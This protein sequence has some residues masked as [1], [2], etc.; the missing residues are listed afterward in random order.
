MVLKKKKK[1]ENK[2]PSSGLVI[3]GPDDLNEVPEGIHNFLI[4]MYGPK[5]IGKTTMASRFP[6]SVIGMLERGR[7]GLNIRQLTLKSF[8]DCLDF[9][10]KCIQ[11]PTV[12][13]LVFDT[14]DV[15]Y[16]QCLL[17]ECRSRGINHP[18]EMKDFG[19][20]WAVIKDAFRDFFDPI[21]ESGK[22]CLCLSHEKKDTVEP[23]SGEPYDRLKPSCSN[24]AY[25]IVEE[26]FDFILYYGKHGKER[27]ISVRP[28]DEATMEVDCCVGPEGVF[29]DPNGEPLS[30]FTVPNDPDAAFATLISAYENEVWDAIRGKPKKKKASSEDDE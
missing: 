19:A 1:P 14:I 7:R 3:P 2:K 16:E 26:A 4:L 18:G 28:F 10:D 15:L 13:T 24:G 11:D 27:A 8:E 20:T 12:D 25:A 21:R 30:I 9:R 5:A 23:R 17:A 29:L 6:G 22:G